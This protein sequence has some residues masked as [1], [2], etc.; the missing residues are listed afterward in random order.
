MAALGCGVLTLVR[1][2]LHVVEESGCDCHSECLQWAHSQPTTVLWLAGR[3]LRRITASVDAE[4]ELCIWSA[5]I[6]PNGDIVSGDSSGRVSIWD[7]KFGSLVQSLHQH[8]AD[9]LCVATS[10]D[11]SH[12]FAS[13]IDSQVAAFGRTPAH[14]EEPP[15]C[16]PHLG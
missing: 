15:R 12:I 1:H 8:D 7:P 6:L 10:P 9:V 4:P 13:G 11:G 5:A 14:A 3:E 16:V 2:P